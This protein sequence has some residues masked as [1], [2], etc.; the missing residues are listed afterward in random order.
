[1]PAF[2]GGKGEHVGFEIDTVYGGW[3]GGKEKGSA[4][5]TAD[6]WLTGNHA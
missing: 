1:M 3:E 6:K 4:G 2:G 5:G